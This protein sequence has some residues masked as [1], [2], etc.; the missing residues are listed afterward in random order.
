MIYEIVIIGGGF[1]GV[2]VAKDLVSASWRIG[3]GIHITLIDKNKYH[4]FYPNF[5]E[6]A[7]AYLPEKFTQTASLE[8]A[9]KEIY[10]H[11]LIKTSSVY[12]EEIFLNDLNVFI[13]EDEAL[14]IDFKNREVILRSGNKKKYDFLVVGVGSETNYFNDLLLKERA[15]PLR[16]LRD[17]LLVRNAID[18]LFA[19]SPKNK[20][21]KIVIGGGGFTGCEFAAE[22]QG[23][24]KTLSQIHG[25]P[26][27]YVECSI[28]DIASQ[29]LS[30]ASSYVQHKTQ[31]RLE[32]L[33]VKINLN[34]SVNS[35]HDFDILVW[36]CGV[37]ANSLLKNL[38][39]VHLEKASCVA[40]DSYMR[41][42]PYE[43]VFGVGDAI[44]CINEKTGKAMPMTASMAIR[45]AKYVAPNIKRSI[46]KKKLVR[47]EPN[48][49]GFI[50]PLG[51]KYAIFEKGNIHFSG[52]IPWVMKHLI[53]LNYWISIL[54]IRKGLKIWKNG[55]KIFLK[56]D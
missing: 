40:I 8:Q 56:N 18:E 17:A 42:L 24:L 22:L 3:E 29:L 12:F 2:R 14:D 26:E 34:T 21:L 35:I 38:Q 37:V 45:E 51:G 27:H 46:E 33:G 39:G 44:Y 36:T 9:H 13:L 15:L 31:E 10:F 50:I 11:E 19:N 47:Y 52:I 41:I 28:F 54:G 20:L 32:S 1:G 4:S 43:D 25:R 53:S 16:D 7:T 6:I 55:M 48:F 30:S 49:P 23:Y 5:Y